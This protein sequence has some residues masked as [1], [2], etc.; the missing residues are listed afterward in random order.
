MDFKKTTAQDVP[1]LVEMIRA[2]RKVTA[3]T[4][5]FTKTTQSYILRNIPPD[6]LILVAMEL[7]KPSGLAEVL[8]G[9]G[10]RG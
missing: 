9:E 5:T 8:S 2:L 7:S 10:P 6:V 1:A 4:G 3:E